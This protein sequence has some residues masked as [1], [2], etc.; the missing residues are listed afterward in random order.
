MTQHDLT[1]RAHHWATAT[2]TGVALL[3]VLAHTQR[4]D[5]ADDK[6]VRAHVEQQA[7]AQ[8]GGRE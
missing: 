5:E 8:M 4:Q 2:I 7:K 6:A 1:A 3:A